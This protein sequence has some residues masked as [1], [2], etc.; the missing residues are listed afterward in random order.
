[1]RTDEVTIRFRDGVNS[2]GVTT[3]AIELLKML[4]ASS[5]NPHI[6]VSSVA[7]TPYDQA[8]VMYDNC[9]KLGVR[10]QYDLYAR[11]GDKVVAVYEREV[12]QGKDKNAVIKAMQAKIMEIGPSRVSRHCVDTSIMNVFDVPFSSITNKKEFRRALNKFHPYPISRYL[13][14]NSNNCFH[15]EMKLT[16][17][18]AFFRTKEYEGI[19]K[20][21]GM[22]LA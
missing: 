10:S 21:L 15:I 8:R 16:D 13:D 22:G 1:M 20:E 11:A 6:D 5:G 12:K 2:D 17:V 7:R 4:G 19:L 3:H 14:E 9:L 18:E